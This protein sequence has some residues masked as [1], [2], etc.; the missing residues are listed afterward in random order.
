MLRE[1]E[2]VEKVE[3]PPG[4]EKKPN[5]TWRKFQ[6]AWKLAK[7]EFSRLDDPSTH[8]T[9]WEIGPCRV[10]KGKKFPYSGSE[11]FKACRSC[12][13]TGD[14]SKIPDFP[15]AV[16][17]RKKKSQTQRYKIMLKEERDKS[18]QL[19]EVYSSCISLESM[20]KSGPCPQRDISSTP[21]MIGEYIEELSNRDKVL[22]VGEAELKER[23]I[24]VV[25][26]EME[27]ISVFES[28]VKESRAVFGDAESAKIQLVGCK[29]QIAGLEKELEVTKLQL[30]RSEQ[31]SRTKA[32][33]QDLAYNKLCGQMNALANQIRIET[34][35]DINKQFF[36][37]QLAGVLGK[38]RKPKPFQLSRELPLNL[39]AAS[40][41][42]D[43]LKIRKDKKC[44]FFQ[45]GKCK[46]GGNCR[47]Y[48]D[49][50]DQVL[51]KDKPCRF[52]QI[53]KCKN[54][55]NCRFFHTLSDRYFIA[56]S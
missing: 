53:G 38:F 50:A 48:H 49:V 12:E 56:E 27:L 25:K 20:I 5:N 9:T 7:K 4:L 46:H 24:L 40:H 54:G 52:F 29:N 31:E 45:V 8:K 26:K 11:V 34:L 2:E 41:V 32:K 15:S 21:G 47:Y 22:V 14:N 30:L 36:A 28:S 37:E 13:G 39:H 35:Q 17:K 3:K 16:K 18:R 55:R 19:E 51:E 23:E 1:G 44:Q 10:C 33:G 6:K 43:V 42:R